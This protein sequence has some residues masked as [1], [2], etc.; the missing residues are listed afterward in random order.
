MQ[1]KDFYNHLCVKLSDDGG[2]MDPQAMR[3]CMGFGFSDKKSDSAIGRC[4]NLSL[5][6][7]NS[8]IIP[9]HISLIIIMQ[10]ISL[11]MILHLILHFDY[12]SR[13]LL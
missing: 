3:N 5:H 11:L 2:G 12:V 4:M 10:D 7:L 8:Y 6:S 13:P 1:K 9:Q